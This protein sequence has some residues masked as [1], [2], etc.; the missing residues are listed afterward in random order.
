MTNQCS[1]SWKIFDSFPNLEVPKVSFK[2]RVFWTA[3]WWTIF[4]TF[5]SY[6]WPTSAVLY[7]IAEALNFLYGR[8][9]LEMVLEVKLVLKLNLLENTDFFTY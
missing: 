5:A 6:S 7:F 1:K 8:F 2:K 4:V 3:E 9:A